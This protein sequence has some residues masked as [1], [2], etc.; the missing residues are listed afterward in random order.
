M[1]RKNITAKL[2]VTALSLSMMGIPTS[3][4]AYAGTVDAILKTG[5]VQISL[6]Q[7]MLD[8]NGDRVDPYDV[9]LHPT[10][11][12]SYIVSVKNAFSPSYIRVKV[13]YTG[14]F[15]GI[16]D[17]MLRGVSDKW[18]KRGAYWYYTEPVGTASLTDFCTSL[19]MPE[20]PESTGVPVSV[21]VDADAV[22][23]A[24]FSP[25]FSSETPWG[26]VEIQSHTEFDDSVRTDSGDSGFHITFEDLQDGEMNESDDLF[27]NFHSLMPG[28][29]VSENM[30][31]K[32]EYDRPIAI[33]LTADN[34]DGDDSLNEWVN[35]EIKRLASGGAKEKVVYDGPLYG[36]GLEE[37]LVMG[38]IGIDKSQ[39]YKITL[40]LD[41]DMP[42]ETMM[43]N[44][45]VSW[46]IVSTNTT[47]GGGSEN[48]YSGGG[49]GVNGTGNVANV[50]EQQQQQAAVENNAGATFSG[51]ISQLVGN[52]KANYRAGAKDSNGRKLSSEDT[53]LNGKDGLH[54]AYRD[55]EDGMVKGANRDASG[56][57]KTGDVFPF[58]MLGGISFLGML[59]LIF[60]GKKKKKGEGNA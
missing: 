30:T 27:K 20:F 35:V 52:I 60:S 11:E 14:E 39:K 43:K 45:S 26:D 50:E 44:Y 24:N 25:D 53:S 1:L 5:G 18:V 28:D 37:N 10:E 49:N 32:N 47:S 3:V 23:A 29:T 42:N 41:S 55:G 59:G 13:N 9:H 46:D 34:S 15:D 19:V 4:P 7:K 6:E 48:G 17:T 54:Y 16:D 12:V 2:A 36:D 22:Q 31:I 56:N 51:A 21:T 8:E 38:V 58:A 57:Y 40:T 33:R